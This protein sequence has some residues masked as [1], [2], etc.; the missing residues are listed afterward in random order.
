VGV[1]TATLMLY[2]ENPGGL[3]CGGLR[4][5]G[6]GISR[7]APGRYPAARGNS[8][9]SLAVRQRGEF[10][11][12][13]CLHRQPAAEA[14][15]A[16]KPPAHSPFAGAGTS[17]LLDPSPWPSCSAEPAACRMKISEEWQE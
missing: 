11:Y 14:R 13:R 17:S 10:A 2:R 9:E 12:A 15:Y 7:H 8:S 16:R 4:I 1:D 6:Q 3:T 5:G